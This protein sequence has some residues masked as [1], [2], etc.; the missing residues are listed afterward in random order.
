MAETEASREKFVDNALKFLIFYGFDGVSRKGSLQPITRT[1][2][3]VFGKK[4]D[5]RDG[6]NLS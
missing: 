3:K 1:V 5:G 2:I 6:R 4:L